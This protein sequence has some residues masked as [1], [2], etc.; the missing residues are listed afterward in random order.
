MPVIVLLTSNC[1]ILQT[2]TDMP[3]IAFSVKQIYF[4]LSIQQYQLWNATLRLRGSKSSFYCEAVILRTVSYFS[5]SFLN[6]FELI[7]LPA[8]NLLFAKKEMHRFV[9]INLNMW[10]YTCFVYI[11]SWMETCCYPSFPPGAWLLPSLVKSAGIVNKFVRMFSTFY[12]T[13][14]ASELKFKRTFSGDT[15]TCERGWTMDQNRQ[16]CVFGS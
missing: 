9:S 5:F 2:H 10:Y 3:A 15:Y 11:L 16:K 12:F 14:P 8:C 6:D 7:L 1:L 13:R 4:P